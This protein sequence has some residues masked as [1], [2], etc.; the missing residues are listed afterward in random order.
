MTSTTTT[1]KILLTGATGYIGGTILSYLLDSS[2]PTLS[3][4]T[5]SCLLRGPDR[6]AKLTATYGS[7]VNPIVYKDLDDIEATVAAAAEHDI[8]ISTT[9]GWHGGSSQALIRGLAQRKAA[10]GRDVWFVQTSGTSNVASKAMTKSDVEKEHRELDDLKDDIYAFEKE[11]ENEAAYAQRTVELAVVDTG[12]ELGVKTLVIMSPTIYGFGKGLWNKL[13]IQIPMI[14]SAVLKN[15]RPVVLGDGRGVWDHV[16][17]E[18]LAELYLLVVRRILEKGGEGV[19]TGKKGIIFSG[20]GRHSSL[21]V[22]LGVADAFQAKGLLDDQELQSLT[23]SD[24][25][26]VMGAEMVSDDIVELSL[27][28]DSRTVSSV[29]RG[30]G[31]NP[32][33][34]EEAWKREFKDVV[35]AVLAKAA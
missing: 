1:P 29:A 2:S 15:K 20:N 32:T 14:A 30:L 34:G 13:S 3:T 33:R 23:V 24:V 5:I 21:D 7:R 4:A 25:K 35:E 12:L 6:A 19:P 10:T 26:K 22:T 16:H 11:R 31:W 17:V 8:I 18:D 9:H 28:S 27:A